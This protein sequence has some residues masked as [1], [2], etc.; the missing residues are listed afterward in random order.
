MSIELWQVTCADDVWLQMTEAL[1]NFGRTCYYGVSLGFRW[2]HSFSFEI[3]ARKVEMIY[4][5]I[6]R[7]GRPAS[8]Y[9]SADPSQFNTGGVLIIG[10]ELYVQLAGHKRLKP[11][12]V[13]GTRVVSAMGNIHF[14]RRVHVYFSRQVHVYFS[15]R[16]HVL[17]SSSACILLSSSACI[18]LS[19]RVHVYF[20]RQVHAPLPV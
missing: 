9:V 1:K 10:Y 3:S 13:R 16:V 17:L 14:S 12:Q 19:R 2:R 11:Q 18:L 4:R 8:T 7:V 20:S 15:R 6:H 5:L